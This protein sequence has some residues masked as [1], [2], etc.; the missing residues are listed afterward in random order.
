MSHVDHARS[1]AGE[2][3]LVIKHGAFGDLIQAEGA[4]RDI[5]AGL[6]Q[7]EVVLLTTPPYRR[8]MERCP[9]VDRL[10]LDKRAPA[11]RILDNLRLV[12]A[13]RAERFSRVFDLQKSGRSERY[14][15]WVL[16]GLPWCGRQPGQQPVSMIEGFR[17]QLVSAG[18]R[19]E[20]C[21]A[22]DVSWMAD[23]VGALLAQ[24]GVAQSYI[25]LIPGC[26]ARHP[27]KRWPYYPE[28]ARRLIALGHCVVTAP[29]PDELE[30]TKSVPGITLLGARGFID[31][32]QL[33]GV[34][35]RAHFVIG[36]DTGPSHLAACLGRPGL[37]LFGPHS[38][39][40]RTGIRRGGFDAIDVADLSAL[41]VDQVLAM[42]LPRL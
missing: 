24:A 11:W 39:S 9:H 15:R 41:P 14:R 37:A 29:G 40:A 10:L 28:L 25:V 18:L 8:L 26:A 16:R 33:A 22:P 7:A 30:L 42:V 36:N 27:H 20:H 31:W 35:K 17:P 1:R 13:L 21:L 32:F 38:S 5:R 3:I 34:L 6:P 2:K 12:H 4:L 23:D 19:A